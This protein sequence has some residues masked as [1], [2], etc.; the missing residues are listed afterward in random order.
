MTPQEVLNTMAAHL[1]AQGVKSIDAGSGSCRYRGRDGLKC[2]VGALLTNKEY[3]PE[4]EGH[5]VWYIEY[6]L[7]QRLVAH[8]GLIRSGQRIHDGCPV[9]AWPSRLR[10]IAEEFGLEIPEGCRLPTVR[11]RLAPQ[12]DPDPEG[13]GQ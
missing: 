11:T 6:I 2:A 12:C 9:E 8:L 10:A 1:L 7:P 3:Y 4:M 5:N 13:E